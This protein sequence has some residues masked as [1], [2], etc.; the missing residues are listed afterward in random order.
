MPQE[1]LKTHTKRSSLVKKASGYTGSV[2]W[3][4]CEKSRT[5]G[6]QKGRTERAGMREEKKWLL[7]V[8]GRIRD[9]IL[10]TEHYFMAMDIKVCLCQ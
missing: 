5:W 6:S 1:I 7:I 2:A 9:K 8:G 3:Q 10:V 4:K